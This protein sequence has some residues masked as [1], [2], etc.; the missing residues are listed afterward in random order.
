MM[1]HSVVVID[2]AIVFNISYPSR[3]ALPTGEVVMFYNKY[4]TEREYYE[5]GE[6]A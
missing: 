3:T 1:M 6:N 4:L 2:N 5:K